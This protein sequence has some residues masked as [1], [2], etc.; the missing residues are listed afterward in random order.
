M[1]A[2]RF[3]LST[4][5]EDRIALGA[6]GRPAIAAHDRLKAAAGPAADLFAEPVLDRGDA[7]PSRVSWYAPSPEEPQPFGRLAPAARSAAETAL[8]ARLSALWPLLADPAAAAVLRPALA[9][10]S[11]DD[12]LRT[13]EAPVLVNWG[14]VPASV[15]DRP[16]ALAAHFAA[17]L[18]PYAPPGANPFLGGGQARP[19]GP[20]PAGAP[21]APPPPPPVPPAAAGGGFAG[22]AMRAIAAVLTAILIVLLVAAVALAA[23]YYFGWHRMVEQLRASAPPPRDPALD[24]EVRRIQ[25]G[26]NEGLRRRIQRLELALR[27]DVCVAPEGPLPELPADA[28]SGPPGPGQSRPVQPANRLPALPPP[29]EQQPVERAPAAPGRPPERTNLADLLDA[30]VV[31]VI[32]EATLPNGERGVSTGSGFAIAPDL[33]ATNLHVVDGV[34]PGALFVA[35]RALGRPTPAEV[36]ART[37]GHDFGQPDFAVLRLGQGRL[38]PLTLATSVDRLLP[39]IA[40][41][42][43]GFVTQAGDDFQR[44]MRGEAGPLPGAHF[45]S[46]EVGAVQDFRSQRVVIHTAAISRGNS[47]GP[48]ADRCG[49]VVGINT[50]VRA[51]Q[52]LA[53]RADYALPAQTLVNFLRQ[54]NIPATVTEGECT[55]APPTP[56]APPATPPAAAPAAPPAAA[57]APATP[58][59]PA[60]P[61]PPAAPPAR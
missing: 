14:I 59:A 26:V 10:P 54:N 5:L 21:G 23:G 27:G 36:V 30:S 42:Y 32:G 2:S 49:R 55:P 1:S 48:L 31:L 56:A 44:M 51:D 17:T 15:G 34:A 53:Y 43:P 38:A 41:G 12:I 19:P 57:P 9:I 50:F 7:A 45:T 20:V 4:G 24:G 37:P 52:E 22:R 8:R 61:T 13:G 58:P 29:P 39:V 18:G 60:A 46:G 33:I 35:N 16:E 25:E 47:G 3:L 6:G 28:P 11:P 40:V